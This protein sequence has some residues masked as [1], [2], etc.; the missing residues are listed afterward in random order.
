MGKANP[1]GKTFAIAGKSFSART[2][3]E[4]V[5]KQMPLAFEGTAS[6]SA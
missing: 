5:Q 4:P 3:S 2:P 6:N 1:R